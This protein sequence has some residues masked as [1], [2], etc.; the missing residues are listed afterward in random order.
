MVEL[1]V[2]WGCDNASSILIL[3]YK[4]VLKFSIDNLSCLHVSL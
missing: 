3:L 2:H 1:H 4:V